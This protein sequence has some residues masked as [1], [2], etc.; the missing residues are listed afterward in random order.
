MSTSEAR[1]LIQQ[2]GV[3]V[4]GERATSIEQQTP[5]GLHTV[6][7]GKRRIYKVNIEIA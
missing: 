2:G 3:E 1:R 7:I 4:D 5:A 6:K